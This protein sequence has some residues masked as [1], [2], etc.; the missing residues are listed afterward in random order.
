MVLL[1][2]LWS[3][4]FTLNSSAS[5]P[6][7]NRNEDAVKSELIAGFDPFLLF[8]ITIITTLQENVILSKTK[9]YFGGIFCR[10]SF[11]LFTRPIPIQI[12]V[13]TSEML[14]L[15][16]LHFGSDPN[17]AVFSCTVKRQT[18]DKALCSF[19]YSACVM[20]AWEKNS[21][22]LLQWGNKLKI[23]SS[24]EHQSKRKDEIKCQHFT[25][26]FCLSK[27]TKTLRFSSS[28]ELLPTKINESIIANL[29]EKRVGPIPG[30]LENAILN[31]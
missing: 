16:S 1:S 3:S 22:L 11:L 18:Q 26:L 21:Q 8:K 23:N 10:G 9:H 28:A 17:P 5:L 25:P 6:D 2:T 24:P 30:F 7:F 29:Q 20:T 31:S 19:I 15:T 13:K 4:K 12:L 27:T 14:P